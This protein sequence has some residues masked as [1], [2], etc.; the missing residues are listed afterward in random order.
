MGT[1]KIKGDRFVRMYRSSITTPAYS[2]PL[3]AATI[4]E[5]LCNC[6]WTPTTVRNGGFPAHSGSEKTD[7]QNVA[8]RELFDAYEFCA[9]HA[10]G[11]H[12]AYAGAA[13]YRFRL[14]TGNRGLRLTS[15]K[16][17][18][19]CDPYN[20]SGARV[21]VY[22]KDDPIL[23]T[24]CADCRNGNWSTDTTP[25]AQ[26][27]NGSGDAPATVW[28]STNT[29]V[30]GVSPR[31]EETN[32]STTTWYPNSGVAVISPEGGLPLGDY[33][34]VFVGLEN[35]NYARQGYL[36]GSASASPVMEITIANGRDEAPEVVSD[37]SS[38]E[39]TSKILVTH[40]PES[41][42]YVGSAVQTGQFC[43][44][45]ATQN[46]ICAIGPS[47]TNAAVFPGMTVFYS[48][49]HSIS[50]S[51]GSTVTEEDGNTY[52]R[53]QPVKDLMLAADVTG[54][55]LSPERSVSFSGSTEYY[56]Q[57]YVSTHS[58]TMF[59][60]QLTRTSSSYKFL[61]Y[62]IEGFSLFDADAEGGDLLVVK[63]DGEG[64]GLMLPV[65]LGAASLTVPKLGELAFDGVATGVGQ[66]VA[67]GSGRF[68]LAG[69][70]RS[71]GGVPVRNCCI[72][73][74]RSGG[75]R[76]I[77]L[78]FDGQVT[79]DGYDGFRLVATSANSYHF[80]GG[81]TRL[82]AADCPAGSATVTAQGAITADNAHYIDVAAAGGY[83]YRII[84]NVTTV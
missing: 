68:C 37:L 30:E 83:E 84:A 11:Q 33:L 44:V 54:V 81:F 35:Y 77:P 51:M 60:G 43:R 82:G 29:H 69:D 15:L 19:S 71:V 72:V 63:E 4:A 24:R 20:A 58:A 12:R 70:F 5:E 73:D 9:E 67:T 32:G 34:F 21:A 26:S 27:N 36:E 62:N 76:V 46:K 55:Y 1:Y 10:N 18:I 14:P 45:F 56:T 8:S 42:L 59:L 80:S 28:T 65:T 49:N 3:D 16:V 66:Y 39:G 25:E 7:Q 52:F 74:M 31:K 23:P 48:D 78:D 50:V 38:G 22:T 17:K 53:S 61:P 47:T 57:V 13:Y 40:L 2:A 64:R 75:F 6:E 41:S 79:P